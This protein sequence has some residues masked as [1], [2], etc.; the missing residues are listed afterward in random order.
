LLF[1]AIHL[2]GKAHGESTD[3]LLVL[4]VLDVIEVV[5]DR[6][7]VGGA[8]HDK[9]HTVA[10]SLTDDGGVGVA[11]EQLLELLV[12]FIVVRRNGDQS[13]AKTDAV[14]DGLV[15]STVPE[16]ILQVVDCLLGVLVLV[17]ETIREVSTS[18]GVWRVLLVGD[19]CTSE[20]WI[21]D[22]ECL[23]T[24][25]C[26]D[27]TKR[28]RGIESVPVLRLGHPA[29]IVLQEGVIGGVSILDCI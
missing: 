8:D 5:L 13:K 12:D 4:L 10:G 22:V 9:A 6:F 17:D 21:Q 29:E 25:A 20:V 24:V 26:M 18:C 2:E 28:G 11:V 27:Q 3:D 7:L 16:A 1:L 14:L 23:L 15:L 19:S